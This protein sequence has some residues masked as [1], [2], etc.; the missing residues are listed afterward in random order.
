M[1][2]S[3]SRHGGVNVAALAVVVA[4]AI[5]VPASVWASHLFDDVPGDYPFHPEISAVAGAGI[6]TGFADGGFHPADPITRQAMAAFMERGPGR[7]ATCS[8]ALTSSLTAGTYYVEVH[9][10][11]GASGSYR[12]GV[13][14]FERRG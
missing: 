14:V 9:G 11:N 5:T 12:P 1:N 2:D 4:V 7:V 8:S 10:V 6:T 13:L 3:V